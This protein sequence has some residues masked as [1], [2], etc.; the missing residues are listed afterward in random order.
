MNK[1]LLLILT[2]LIVSLLLF[3][4]VYAARKTE[5]AVAEKKGIGGQFLDGIWCT[6]KCGW[7]AWILLVLPPVAIYFYKRFFSWG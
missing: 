2:V 6:L 1:K 4:A 3:S 5:S 7:P